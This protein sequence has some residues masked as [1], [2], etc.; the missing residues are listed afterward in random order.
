MS[1]PF[2]WLASSSPRRQ[3]LLRQMGVDFELVA[4]DV[5]ETALP[6]EGAEQMALRLAMAKAR[7]GLEQVAPARGPVLGSDT[8]VTL[9]GEIFGKPAN[10]GEALAMLERLSGRCHQVITAV[11][12][13]GVSI[14]QSVSCTTRVW[15]RD[16]SKAER[17]AYWDS[18]EP[19][20]KAGGYGI[21]GRAAL[22]VSRID[23]SYSGVMG[24]PIYETAALLGQAGISLL[25]GAAEA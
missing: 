13:A 20:D 2:V 14:E 1:R 25:G 19:A 7:A 11:A 21:Q 8:V 9:D 6:D 16:T 15:F 24:L 22:F 17:E 3:E 4:V 10:R 12:L 5:P 23:G 18:G